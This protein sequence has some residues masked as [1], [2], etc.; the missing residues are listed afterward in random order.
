MTILGLPLI[1]AVIVLLFLFAMIGAGLWSSRGVKGDTDFFVAGRRMGPWLTFFLNFG[2]FADSN[3]AP[4]M[5]TGVYK[6]GAGGTWLSFWPILNTPIYW[7]L[8]VWWRRTRLITAQDQFIERFNSKKLA[9]FSAMVGVL[10]A[11][12]GA[13]LGNVITFKVAAAMFPKPEAEYTQSER[14]QIRDYH[15]YAR[16]K[17]G[18]EAGKLAS[19]ERVRFA[20]L[21][22]RHEAGNLPSYISYLKPNSFYIFYTLV[23]C[24]LVIMGGIKATAVTDAICGV[25]VIIFSIFLIPIGLESIGGFGALREKVPAHMFDL[26]GSPTMSDYAWYTILALILMGM[27]GITTPGGCGVAIDEKTARIGLLGGAFSR[28]VVMIFWMFAALIAIAVFPHGTPQELSDP[29]NA[30]GALSRQLLGPGFLGVMVAGMLIGHMPNVGAGAVNFA[31]TF[32][33]NIYEPFFPG[34]SKDHYML[35]AKLAVFGSLAIGTISAMFFSD[36]ISLMLLFVSLGAI[37]GAIGFLML[38]WRG[39]SGRAVWVAWIFW[40]V[41][42]GLLPWTLPKVESFRQAPGLL[43]FNEV[44]TVTAE[45]R[46]SGA[47]VA[48]GLAKLPGEKIRKTLHVTPDP[49]F[50]DAIVAA[51]S[52]DPQSPREGI[53]RFHIEIYALHLLGLPVEKL[54]MA[55]LNA[56]RFL[57][58]A[59]L[60]FTLLIVL[61]ILLP[62]LPKRAKAGRETAPIMPVPPE[63]YAGQQG[64][65]T[66]L[67]DEVQR[68][69]RAGG[70]P[71]GRVLAHIVM[72]GNIAL[73]HNPAETEAQARVRL[74]RFFVKL[75]TPVAPTPELD[76]ENIAVSLA[77]TSRFDHCRL[78]HNSR[79][80]FQRWTRGD[81]IGFSACCGGVAVVVAALVGLL[82]ICR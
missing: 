50:F 31:A 7:F 69:L 77:D 64:N 61:S 10:L 59:V 72:N 42:I 20:E 41:F 63:A 48:A 25:V 73:L 39:L 76:E 67:E 75:K 34:R 37:N 6:Q 26:F 21:N 3:G 78:F 45:A 22:E 65:A 13:G 18:F 5:A 38:F 60:P 17:S 12:L 28:R 1:D 57:I 27:A 47:D 15:E 40:L 68:V 58:T 43:K 19:G 51:D 70:V 24:L 33:R 14:G 9:L 79:W 82:E 8:A 44:T 29:D 55:G 30:W 62:D 53:G 52:T 54:G 11:P 81:V 32:T 71:D 16:L 36:I 46:A 35:V 23:V 2:S 49:L 74:D 66:M 80:E 4:T 56:C